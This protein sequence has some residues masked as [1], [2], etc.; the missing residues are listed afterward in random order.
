MRNGY[1]GENKDI[2]K[3]IKIKIERKQDDFT[4]TG[5]YQK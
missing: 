1:K 3:G 2:E 4:G 5:R